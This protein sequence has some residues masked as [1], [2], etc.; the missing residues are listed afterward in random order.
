[1]KKLFLYDAAS[2]TAETL[3]VM[4]RKGYTCIKLTADPEFFWGQIRTLEDMDVL[5]L[6]SHGDANGPLA[7]AGNEGGDI[8]LKQFGKLISEKKLQLYLLSCHTGENPCANSLSD[9]KAQFAAPLGNAV[10]K[11]T[12]NETVTVLSKDGETFPGWA[13]E[14][15]PKGRASKP[16]SL[17]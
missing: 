11:T 4:R 7:V 8:N 10:F 5:V 13:G 2:I 9:A 1:M 17:P 16:L 15:A 12:G 3:A 14:L 6:L